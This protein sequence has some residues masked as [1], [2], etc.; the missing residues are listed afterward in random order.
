[1]YSSVCLFVRLCVCVCAYVFLALIYENG[2]HILKFFGFFLL[3]MSNKIIVFALQR[4]QLFTDI[5]NGKIVYFFK[6]YVFNFLV[7]ISCSFNCR[8]FNLKKK[9]VCFAVQPKMILLAFFCK[10]KLLS[11]KVRTRKANNNYDQNSMSYE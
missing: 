1:M 9:L 7:L 10:D 11:C 5:F 8:K 2:C 4:T 3:F 6:A